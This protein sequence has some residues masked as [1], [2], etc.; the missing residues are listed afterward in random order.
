MPDH[1][2]P[3]INVVESDLKLLIKKDIKV[4]CMSMEI[5]YEALFKVGMLDEEQEKK[6]ENKDGE[7][8]Y[9]QYHKRSVGH[10]LQDCQDF[11][12]LV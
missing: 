9:C 2:R 6:E 7:W 10:P 12:D 1:Q 8:K 4:V 5:V 11:L 3:K